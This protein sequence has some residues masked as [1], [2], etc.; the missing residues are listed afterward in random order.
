MFRANKEI[1]AYCKGSKKLC[2]AKVCPILVKYI[3]LLNIVPNIARKRDI[4]GF[5]PPNLLVGEFGYPQVNIGP[6]STNEIRYARENPETW[7]K[8][9]LDL[10]DIL[11]MRL[12]MLYAF[13]KVRITKPSS[14][15]NVLREM[16]I[17]IKP[18]DIDVYLKKEPRILI[19]LN[20]DIPPIG[21][22]GILDKVEVTGNPITTRKVEQAIEE[23]VKTSIIV[24]ELWKHGMNFYYI[25]RLLSAG[26]LGVRSRRRIVPTRWSITATDNI[27]SNFFLKSIKSKKPVIEAALHYWEYLGNIYYIILIPNDFWAMEMF[28]IW[29]PLSVW[30]KASNNP[31]L[32]HIYEDYDGKPNKIDGGYMA[33]RYSVLEHLRKIN[34]IAS[35][36]A[37]RIITPKY[38]A[39]VG[40]WQI[41]ES[42]RLALQ[43]KPLMKGEPDKLLRKVMSI[44]RNKVDI[45][46]LRRSWLLKRIS[47]PRLNNLLK[48]SQDKIS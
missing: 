9:G 8:M 21:A 31:V 10:I 22:S 42:V 32:I 13:Q 17:S 45:D 25:Q 16:I 30:V 18:I 27:L 43:S 19:K 35:V 48:I 47:S 5:S 6:I 12:N 34:R 3:S 33:I 7:A 14:I 26:L 20:A 38:F 24:P 36:I 39:P 1:C 41:R 2:G 37:I 29:L 28:E 44:E 46:L 23:D 15:I 40:S 4:E 11:K